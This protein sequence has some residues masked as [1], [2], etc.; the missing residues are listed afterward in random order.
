MWS[1]GTGGMKRTASSKW[2]PSTFEGNLV[3]QRKSKASAAALCV[4]DLFLSILELLEI[5]NN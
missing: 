2:L 1:V 5:L 4:G 3:I